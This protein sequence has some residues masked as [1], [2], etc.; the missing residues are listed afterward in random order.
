MMRDNAKLKMP[1]IQGA[2]YAPSS[3]IHE[4]P[5]S[6]YFHHAILYP[7]SSLRGL[8]DGYEGAYESPCHGEELREPV[9]QHGGNNAR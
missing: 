8:L 5:I 9:V 3:D 6:H 4:K 7:P 1:H 2:K